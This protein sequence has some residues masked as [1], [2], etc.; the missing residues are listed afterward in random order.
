M[1]IWKHIPLG[2]FTTSCEKMLYSKIALFLNA[3]DKERH[4]TTEYSFMLLSFLHIEN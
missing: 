2:Y 3:G 1:G 4:E